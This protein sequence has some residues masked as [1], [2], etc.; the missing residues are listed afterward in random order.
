MH[1][2][3]GA[4]RTAVAPPPDDDVVGVRARLALSRPDG[5]EGRA[6]ARHPHARRCAS[7]AV[8]RQGCVARHLSVRHVRP[9]ARRGGAH[10]LL[11]RHHRQAH[12]RRLL[13]RRHQH[14]D[15]HDRPGRGRRRGASRRPRPD[16][17]PLWHV[18]RRM[19]HAL[20]H[21]AHRR[22][23]HPRRRRAD[24]TPPPHDAG[25][26]HDRARLHALVRPLPRRAGRGAGRRLRVAQAP[27]G[28]VRRRAVLR[29][30][31]RRDRGAARHP[32]HRQLRPLRG[33]GA[34][35]RRRV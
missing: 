8:H 5:R 13:S 29:P 35:G 34:R 10:P 6:A 33:H 4:A 25:L 24:R 2:P 27:P 21:R 16:G 20:R 1:G 22:D 17:V 23:H 12:R 19:G 18:H 7:S 15:R 32:R 26:R 28:A 3:R 30:D 31:D 11:I 9:A 14:L